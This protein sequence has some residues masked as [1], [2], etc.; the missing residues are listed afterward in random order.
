MSSKNHPFLT[1]NAVTAQSHAKWKKNQSFSEA[2]ADVFSS[3][4]FRKSRGLQL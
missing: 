3:V 4:R 1:K 2:S